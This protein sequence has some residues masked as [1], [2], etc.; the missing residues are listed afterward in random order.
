MLLLVLL[1]SQPGLMMWGTSKHRGYLPSRQTQQTRHEQKSRSN[2]QTMEV[3]TFKLHTCKEKARVTCQV[4]IPDT[5][6]L[7]VGL[8]DPYGPFQ[9]EI[10]CDSM[11]I[12]AAET[13]SP[14][15]TRAE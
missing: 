5:Y 6:T 15:D 1:A 11:I 12:K 7:G 13:C 2:G 10:F 4:L 3:S 8:S 9:V 14:T